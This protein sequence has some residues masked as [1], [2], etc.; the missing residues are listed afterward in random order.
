VRGNRDFVGLSCRGLEVS[1]EKERSR[2]IQR[3]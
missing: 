1:R 3:D 2:R